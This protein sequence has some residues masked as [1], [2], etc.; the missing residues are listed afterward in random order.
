MRSI[1]QTVDIIKN[2]VDKQLQ[3]MT[4]DQSRIHQDIAGR[5]DIQ[6]WDETPA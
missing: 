4:I 5:T 2:K 3:E 6:L 1:H